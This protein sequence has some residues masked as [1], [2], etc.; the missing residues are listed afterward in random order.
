MAWFRRPKVIARRSD[1]RFD[2]A[3]PAE[4][5]RTVASLLEQ[6]MQ[7]VDEHPDDPTLRRLQPPAY[8][9]DPDADA[10]YRLLAGEELRASRRATVDRVL[11]TLERD[12]VTE[13]ELWAWMQA[14]NAV[15]LV[16]GTR[17]DVDEGDA[18]PSQRSP[19]SPEEESLWAVYDLTTALQYEV[20]L[21]LGG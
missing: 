16:A 9:D 18:G 11:E 10:A 5:R 19:A 7:I 3:L 13:D 4:V 21:A 2:V 8:L 1:G 15:R 12:V 20:V 17:L 14:L 6:L